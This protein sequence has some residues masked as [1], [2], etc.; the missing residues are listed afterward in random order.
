MRHHALL[1]PTL[2]L[3]LSLAASVGCS[4]SSLDANNKGDDPEIIEGGTEPQPIEDCPDQ[5]ADAFDTYAPLGCDVSCDINLGTTVEADWNVLVVT[6][7]VSTWF[8]LELGVE[9]GETCDVVI[10]CPEMTD[11]LTLALLCVGDSDNAADYCMSEYLECDHETMCNDQYNEC[12]ENA[13]SAYASCTGTP[14]ECW[15][16]YDNFSTAC[17]EQYDACLGVGDEPAPPPPLPTMTSAGRFDVPKP[18]IHHHL[19]RLATLEMQTFTM[20]MPASD[21]GPAGLALHSIQ[22]GDTLDQL[23]LEEG[24][25]IVRI[26]DTS[27]MNFSN[28]PAALLGV[29]DNG[30]VKI[31]IRRNGVKRDLRYRFVD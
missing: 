5:C 15:T 17:I 6:L 31:T 24:D 11:C 8:D 18:F 21:A 29:L 22:P 26:N 2:L 14:E 19:E 13:Y 7:G 30:G 4:N 27:I 16:I 10:E 23:G 25:V 9:T 28:N 20:R 1:S 12:G 3:G